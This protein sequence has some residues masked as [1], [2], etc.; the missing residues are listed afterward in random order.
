MQTK[1][2]QANNDADWEEM[3]RSIEYE[4]LV[5]TV[6]R[7]SPCVLDEIVESAQ[8]FLDAQ[9]DAHRPTVAEP[10]RFTTEKLVN[11]ITR[12]MVENKDEDNASKN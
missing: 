3:C 4:M 8:E 11:Q 12:Q 2:Y 6:V 7:L 9:P 5:R 1:E 10:V